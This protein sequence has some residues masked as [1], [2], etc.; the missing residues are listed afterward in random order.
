MGL[1]SDFV[2]KS[3]INYRIFPSRPYAEEFSKKFGAIQYV[4]TTFVVGR[5]GKILETIVG[6]RDLKAFED[7]INK[8]INN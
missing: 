6:G 2:K 4:P 8:Y 7:I 3:N 1:V 5:D